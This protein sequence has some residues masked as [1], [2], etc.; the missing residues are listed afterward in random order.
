MTPAEHNS[1]HRFAEMELILDEY[2]Q[3]QTEILKKFKADAMWWKERT[4]KELG[5]N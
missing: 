1:Q 2:I 3:E 5:L 4:K